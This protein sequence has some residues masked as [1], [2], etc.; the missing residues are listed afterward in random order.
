[1][2]NIL[3]FVAILSVLSLVLAIEEGTFLE[4]S[5]T[6]DPHS[7]EMINYINSLNT[8]WKAGHNIH[9]KVITAL[10]INNLCILFLCKQR[11]YIMIKLG[12]VKRFF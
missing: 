2:S 1:M 11:I 10:T 6:I 7:E 4:L 5:K 3:K 12:E 9:F 8:T